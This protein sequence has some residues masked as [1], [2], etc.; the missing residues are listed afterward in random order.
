MGNKI[1]C[2]VCKEQKSVDNFSPIKGTKRYRT[3]CHK[4]RRE[5][6]YPKRK[7]AACRIARQ[8]YKDHK[9][10][11]KARMKASRAKNRPAEMLKT[12]KQRAEKHGWDFNIDEGDI[13]IPDICPILGIPLTMGEGH[14]IPNSPSLDRID[15][16]KGYVKG[17]VMVISHRANTIKSNATPEELRKIADFYEAAMNK[18]NTTP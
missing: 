2:R 16:T 6:E 5:V 15:P 12:A 1:L 9:E 7:D 8:Y 18:K 4:C 3:I 14:P 17:N 11:V 13:V 10:E